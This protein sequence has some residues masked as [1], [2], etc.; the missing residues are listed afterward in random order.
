[1]MTNIFQYMN[2]KRDLGLLFSL[3]ML[4]MAAFASSDCAAPKPESG[5]VEGGY[6][7]VVQLHWEEVP[8][9]VSYLIEVEN[10]EGEMLNSAVSFM[11]AYEENIE[12]QLDELDNYKFKVRASYCENGPY[13]EAL[14]IDLKGSI[15]IIDDIIQKECPED[16]SAVDFV[17]NG[18]VDYYQLTGDECLNLDVETLNFNPN[19]NIALGFT[20]SPNDQ[21][22]VV[23]YKGN[24]PNFYLQNYANTVKGFYNGNM[25]FKISFLQGLNNTVYFK[26][27]WSE[28][29][30][31]SSAYCTACNLNAID[32]LVASNAQSSLTPHSMKLSPS[33][34]ELEVQCSEDSWIQVFDMNGRLWY[35]GNAA[36]QFVNISTA[37]WPAALYVVHSRTKNGVLENQFFI[38]L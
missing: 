33:S 10:D 14:R 20:K 1:M 30:K 32:A 5:S 7:N 28:Y 4:S 2:T 36:E 35:E 18:K 31:V 22:I 27:E 26:I 24:T 19:V 3:L 29:L 21:L 13:G 38:K 16:S 6:D 23:D 17:T 11:N 34:A 12:V 37:S 25:L 8:E 15:I 9:A